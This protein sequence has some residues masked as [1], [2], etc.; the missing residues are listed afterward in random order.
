MPRLM[1]AILTL[2]VLAPGVFAAPP[3]HAG[4][5]LTVMTR[6]VYVGFD[7]TVALD[8]IA[9]GDFV[10]IV[11]TSKLAWDTVRASDFHARAH[12]LAAEIADTR[13]EVVGLQEV[14]LFR[15]QEPADFSPTPNAE[16][17]DLDFLQI[18]LEA[19][20][21]RGLQYDPVAIIQNADSELPALRDDFTCC[22]D[23]RL[24]DHDVILARRGVAH[25]G[26]VQEANFDTVLTVPLA[27]GTFRFPRG[28]VSVDVKVHGRPVRVINTHLEALHPGIQ[29]LQG[30]E[31]IN[32]PMNTP[33]PLVVLGDFNSPPDG[34]FSGTYGLLTSSGLVDAW[35]TLR[36]GDPGY[37]CCHDADLRNPTSIL[38][39]RIDIVFTRGD[40]TALDTLIVG[41]DPSER[42]PDGLWPSD[43]AGVVTT[44]RLPPK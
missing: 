36:P 20:E 43:H 17:V 41:A 16:T 3:D 28:W 38:D 31:L 30:L 14:A 12:R 24:T 39:E 1:I 10:R 42:T 2:L 7:V 37:T 21:A 29:F 34:S 8:A 11:T 19:L 33:L 40:F 9:S 18:L 6:N 35:V 26:L 5:R 4:P 25:V 22:R 27:G 15:S 13:P 44:V 23:I 32:G